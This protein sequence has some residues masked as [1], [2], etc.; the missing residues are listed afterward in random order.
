MVADLCGIL[1]RFRIKKYGIVADIKK[2]LPAVR[3][4]PR[5]P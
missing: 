4:E 2:G 5:G 3:I 1:L